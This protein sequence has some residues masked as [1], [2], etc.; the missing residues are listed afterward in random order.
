MAQVAQ[1]PPAHLHPVA[2]RSQNKPSLAGSRAAHDASAQLRHSTSIP[3]QNSARSGRSN[4]PFAAAVSS[5][6]VPVPVPAAEPQTQPDQTF[7]LRHDEDYPTHPHNDQVKLLTAHQYAAL[8]AQELAHD[9]PD[10]ALFPWLHGA[11]QTGTNQAYYFGCT[12]HNP[13]PPP[14]SVLPPTPCLLFSRTT[15]V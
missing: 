3:A 12:P 13:C 5:R 2:L 15:A 7:G 14:K 9:T 1:E 8:A 11:D 4:A 10:Q 6:R